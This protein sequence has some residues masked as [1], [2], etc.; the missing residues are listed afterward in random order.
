MPITGNN[1][2]GIYV[3][4]PYRTHDASSMECGDSPP[5]TM[6]QN[7][8]AISID[9][10]SGS[11]IARVNSV[12]IALLAGS[13]PPSWATLSIECRFPSYDRSEDTRLA[14]W[15]LGTL[16]ES[17]S[18][19]LQSLPEG[20]NNSLY[21]PPEYWRWY[22]YSGA[23]ESERYHIEDAPVAAC[24]T[25]YAGEY[26]VSGGYYENEESPIDSW[27][28]FE[29]DFLS[30]KTSLGVAF[31]GA[32]ALFRTQW[33]YRAFVVA[34]GRTHKAFIKRLQED[35]VDENERGIY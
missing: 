34:A 22:Y 30:Q 15:I 9:W 13:N 35:A 21:V 3:T 10:N 33:F 25:A 28:D 23:H 17:A 6:V 29:I 31:T 4:Y 20:D 26:V 5:V 2:D 18:R 7:P 8:H 1:K 27:G 11:G 24:T 32:D 16:G 12:D 14:S 19:V